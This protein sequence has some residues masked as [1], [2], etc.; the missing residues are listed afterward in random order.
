LGRTRR[1]VPGWRRIAFSAAS[2]R[3]RGFS[4]TTLL[5]IG[6]IMMLFGVNSLDLIRGW[7]NDVPNPASG[8]SF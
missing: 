1:H 2:R 6:D 5:I 7:L 3:P 8:L 4:L